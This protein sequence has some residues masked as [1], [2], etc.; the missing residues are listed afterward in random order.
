MTPEERK[1]YEEE[2]AIMEQEEAL[3]K[4]DEEARAEALREVEAFRRA[5]EELRTKSEDEKKL[6]T[7]QMALNAGLITKEEFEARKA[8]IPN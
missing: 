1:I 8:K 2:K 6:E 7:L 4:A 5:E 3:R